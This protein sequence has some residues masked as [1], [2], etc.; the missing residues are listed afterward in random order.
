MA[1]QQPMKIS[2]ELL[3][4]AD[5]KRLEARDEDLRQLIEQQDRRIEG[6]HRTVYELIDVIGKLRGKR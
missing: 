2:V 3:S 4:S 5:V 1:D 6:L